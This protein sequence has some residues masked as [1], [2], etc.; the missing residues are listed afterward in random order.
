MSL[1]G[2]REYNERLEAA[3]HSGDIWPML[4]KMLLADILMNHQAL[5]GPTTHATAT[6]ARAHD[7]IAKR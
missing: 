6:A 7:D 2:L 4:W 3:I 5:H 1:T